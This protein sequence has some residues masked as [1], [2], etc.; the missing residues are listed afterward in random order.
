MKANPMIS[1]ELANASIPVQKA[2]FW[3]QQYRMPRTA[4]E[5]TQTA[6]TKPIALQGVLAEGLESPCTSEPRKK[7]LTSTVVIK[8]WTDTWGLGMEEVTVE[9]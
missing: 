5:V 9:V 8:S 6:T 4:V 3:P 7:P 1:V 2:R